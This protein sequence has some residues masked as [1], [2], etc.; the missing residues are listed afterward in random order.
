MCFRKLK[1]LKL[2]HV[3][4]IA[5]THEYLKKQD[6]AAIKGFN[7]AGITRGVNP[8]DQKKKKKKMA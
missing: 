3:K 7:T 8:F 6:E 4:W 2:L 1:E 5:E